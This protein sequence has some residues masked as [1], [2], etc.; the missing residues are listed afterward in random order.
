MPTKEER[1][2]SFEQSL[3]VE[4]ASKN[5]DENLS[6]V[7]CDKRGNILFLNDK[8]KRNEFRNREKNLL[9]VVC[10]DCRDNVELTLFEG[11]AKA[12]E[13]EEYGEYLLIFSASKSLRCVIWL[14]LSVRRAEDMYSLLR[15]NMHYMEL[16]GRVFSQ[17]EK[18]AEKPKRI[19][20]QRMG[21]I[22]HLLELSDN[23]KETYGDITYDL[24]LF[25]RM[26]CDYANG[27]LAEN[28]GF[29]EF[30]SPPAVLSRFNPELYRVLFCA[31]F[32]LV[33]C[34]SENDNMFVSIDTDENGEKTCKIRFKSLSFS[35][36]A[37]LFLN[38]LESVCFKLELGC[39][40]M[41]DESKEI[42]E[43]TLVVRT[44]DTS[45]GFVRTSANEYEFYKLS[46]HI[47]ALF[48][49]IYSHI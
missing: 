44:D 16:V 19:I 9:D 8:A 37:E 14:D 24:T 38:F 41:C 12:I 2:V 13:L 42:T 34:K 22:M 46:S 43:F 5:L 1:E 7:V 32:S 11:K 45:D 27:V 21:K 39:A 20:S 35:N 18:G 15:D 40:V 30:S 48:G 23:P 17:D 26:L 49:R 29:V 36:G 25:T 10:E 28:D 47:H 4:K 3:E 6:G 33:M 31:C